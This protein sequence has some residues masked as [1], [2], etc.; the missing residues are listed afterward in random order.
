MIE[1]PTPAEDLTGLGQVA[2]A[3]AVPVLADQSVRGPESLL[4]L[5]TGRI[6]DGFSVKLATCGGLH[7]ARQMDAIGRAAK[8]TIM[9]SCVI[10]PALLTAAGLAMALSSPNVRYGDLDG[11]VDL[12]NDP[13]VPGFRLEEGWLT[14]AETPGLG[15]TVE[16]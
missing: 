8:M 2:G 5:S 15:C 9:V 11:H 13:T 10:E 1:Q 16:L 7:C 14:A 4:A 12:V 6:V 3:S